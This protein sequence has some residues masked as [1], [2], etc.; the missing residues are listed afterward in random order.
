M[1]L[2]CCG[3]THRTG[4]L[5][6]REPFQLQRADLADA[7]VAFKRISGIEELV[8]LATCN[9]VEY[10]C[11][12]PIKPDP[13]EA[14]IEFFRSRGVEHPESIKDHWF[15][16]QGTSVARHL[17]KVASGLDS[18]LLGEYQI[19]GQVKEAYSAAC[20]V[21]GPGKFLH[22]LFHQ[23]FQISKRVRSETDISGGVQGLAGASLELVR[24]NLGSDLTGRKALIIG[25][26]S[27]TEM[28]LK[29]L[30]RQNVYVTVANRT[31]YSAEKIVKPYN[32][33]AISLDEMPLALK[34]ADILFSVTSTPGF[35]VI[36][37]HFTER[38]KAKP[39][40]A[41]DL[42]VPRDID[43]RIGEM[44]G[45]VLL[46][47]DDLKYHLDAVQEER[48]ADV[49]IALEII[50]E[51]VRNYEYWR[52]AIIAGGNAALRQIL[53]H[54]R[55]EIIKRFRDGFRESDQKALEALSKNLFR[56][57]L[58]RIDNSESN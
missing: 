46:D 51:Q 2:T 49:H 40:M 38:D 22:K 58:R 3:I 55:Q 41:V 37:S 16:R 6:D 25:V 57:F 29:S 26:N 10:Y 5:N 52:R 11:R 30:T 34:R 44:E 42:A 35:I 1:P 12:G 45:I 17:F 15:F 9:R 14:V 50:E 13:H 21:S 20:S 36:P 56:Q 31:L 18:P 53:E 39:I 19:L 48:E 24:K 8:I 33:T 47:L 32:A 27:S 7:T 23:A 4:S 54:D 43:P 28:L